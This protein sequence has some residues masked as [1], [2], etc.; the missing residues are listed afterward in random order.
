MATVC[1]V[2]FLA[3]AII[4]FS[5]ELTDFN[6]PVDRFGWS[7]LHH[8]ANHAFPKIVDFLLVR[9][10]EANRKSVAGLTPLMAAL[11]SLS[12]FNQRDVYQV[13]D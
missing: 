3:M 2:I 4:S 10:A 9:G 12:Q 8:A 13:M 11:N 7:L 6:T 1:K 5:D